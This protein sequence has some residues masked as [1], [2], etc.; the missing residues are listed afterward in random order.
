L[1]QACELISRY[2][3]GTAVE[4]LQYTID[5]YATFVSTS[6][7]QYTQATA[8]LQQAIAQFNASPDKVASINNLEAIEDLAQPRYNL[9]GQRATTTNGITVQGNKKILWNNL[10]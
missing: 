9:Q 6:P 2:E 7:T 10:K 8:A 5:Q 3:S 1:A 4:A